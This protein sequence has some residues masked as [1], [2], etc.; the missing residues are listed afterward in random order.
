LEIGTWP[1]Y[2]LRCSISRSLTRKLAISSADA[3]FLPL[4]GPVL[5][6]NGREAATA[7]LSRGFHFSIL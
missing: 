1:E 2:R 6:L 3:D 4:V 7:W 5:A